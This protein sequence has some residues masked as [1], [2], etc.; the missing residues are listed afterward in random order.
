MRINVVH[1][2]PRVSSAYGIAEDGFTAAMEIVAD[3][4]EVRW[5]N[6]HPYN[7]D[8]RQQEARR[9]QH[10]LAGATPPKKR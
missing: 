8:H 6:V 5:L 3:R 7:D 10:H 4:H 2:M 9:Y 1:A